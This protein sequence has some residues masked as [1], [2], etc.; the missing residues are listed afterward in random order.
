MVTIN[1]HTHL[2]GCVRLETAAE[3]AAEAGVEPPGASWDEALVM[4]VPSDLTVFLAHVAAAYPLLGSHPALSRVAHEAV[5]D[6]A[7]D[8]CRFWS[9][10]SGRSRTFGPASTSMP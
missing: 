4:R 6:A 2:E 1:L 8:G 7:A 9:C 3:L 10:A 5:V